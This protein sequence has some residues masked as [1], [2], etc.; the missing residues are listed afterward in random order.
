[1]TI[2]WTEDLA[3]GSFQIDMQHKQLF[4]II[5]EFLDAC[6]KGQAKHEI[7]KVVEFMS[8]YVEEHF[9][10]EE[11]FME[12]YSY[13]H[14]AVHKK[15]H[16]EFKK[17]FTDFRDRIYSEGI[18]LSITISLTHA[19]VDWLTKHIRVTDRELAKFLLIK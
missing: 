19:L 2:E 1:M 9:S 16:A 14:I 17:N 4:N 7:V 15:Q 11:G 5:N 12:K 6:K 3:T 10:T 13:P 8:R 18:T